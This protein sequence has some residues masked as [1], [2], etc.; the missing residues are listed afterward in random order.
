M[1]ARAPATSSSV[2]ERSGASTSTSSP[3]RSRPAPTASPR[4][5]WSPRRRSSARAGAPAGSADAAVRIAKLAE[6]DPFT[7]LDGSVIRELAGTGPAPAENQ[8]LAEASV[9]P[10]GETAEHF[11]STSE[12]LYYFTSG[13]GRMRL[14]AEEAD[15]EAGDCVAI[16]PG[17]PHKLWNTGSEPLVLLC[18]CAPP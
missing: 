12:E 11:H 5:R 7:T 17:V 18:C 8:S 6:L 16:A 10:G 3:G 9:P 15:V 4:L 14:G 1:P 2:R 13:A